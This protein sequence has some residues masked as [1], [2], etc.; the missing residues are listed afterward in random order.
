MFLPIALLTHSLSLQVRE[1]CATPAYKDGLVQ[2]N[3]KI[4]ED[5]I[6][7]CLLVLCETVDM[8]GN[9]RTWETHWVRGNI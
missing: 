4:A 3:L 1:I 5:R 9:T 2:G 8:G 7:S 6:L